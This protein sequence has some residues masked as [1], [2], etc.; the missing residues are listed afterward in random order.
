MGGD[1]PSDD[2]PTRRDYLKYSAAVV[3]GGML[4]GCTTESDGATTTDT[5]PDTTTDT[6]STTETT[7][8]QKADSYSVTMEPMGSVEFD[9]VPETWLPYGG[10]Y[11]DMGVALGQADGM[12]GIGQA[13]EYYTDVYDEL[14][15]VDVDEERIAAND[16]VEAEMSKEL[17]YELDSDVHVIDTE[18]LH[19]W[20]DW[21]DSDVSEVRSRV[22]PFLG[23]M[24]F[25]RSDDWHDHRFYTLYQAFE[26]MAELFDERERYEAFTAVHEDFV[27]DLQSRMPPAEDRPNVLLT[28]EGTNEPESF[29]PYRLTDK[30]TSK[31]Q[32][33]DLGVS[34]AL[35]G[36]G[37]ENLST[38]NRSELDY[39]S[40]LEVDPDVLLIRGHEEKSRAEFRDTVIAHMR[41]HAIGGRLTAVENDRVYRGGYLRQGPIQ[42]LF[43]TERAA[44]QLYP[45]E[46]GTVTDDAELFDRE[47]VADIVTGDH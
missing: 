44:K 32:W 30:G 7:K 5:T 16:L 19:H 11:A 39:E 6:T 25:R 18:M 3:T 23:N 2:A 37:I 13:G 4:A 29:S 41:E 26:K 34:D 20:F 46:F 28:Y 38:G 14:P 33:N 17:F 47:E 45:D 9:A 15:G 1:A 36:T 42:N 24:I 43:L 21:S 27:A 12:L 10:D 35:A 31:K 22:G 8:S 40:L